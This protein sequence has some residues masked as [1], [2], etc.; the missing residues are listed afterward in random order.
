MSR[1]TKLTHLQAYRRAREPA[2]PISFIHPLTGLV[3]TVLTMAQGKKL[4]AVKRKG[5]RTLLHTTLAHRRARHL[6]AYQNRAPD[7][8][9]LW[10]EQLRLIEMG[11]P[12]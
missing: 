3:Y 11:S 1:E 6:K 9:P 7:G 2:S 8:D 12:Q 4:R 5:R 10:T